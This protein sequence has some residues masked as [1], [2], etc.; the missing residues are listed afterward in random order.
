MAAK[1][2]AKENSAVDHGHQAW[3]TEFYTMLAV[4]A[5]TTILVKNQVEV[6][7]AQC[8][9][10]RQKSVESIPNIRPN[11]FAEGGVCTRECAGDVPLSLSKLA[12]KEHR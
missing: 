9:L 2:S 3:T 7:C 4:Q 5:S 6:K 12:S 1:C 8:S 10:I 11:S